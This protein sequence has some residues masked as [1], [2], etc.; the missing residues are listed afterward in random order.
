[1][2]NLYGG[3]FEGSLQAVDSSTFNVYGTGLT[4][5]G[6]RLV[7]TL[8]DGTPIDLV[9]RHRERF[10]IYEVPEPSTV[11]L[12]ALGLLS[13]TVFRRRRK[14]QPLMP[15]PMSSPACRSAGIRGGA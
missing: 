15:S 2:V 10:N 3:T 13:L 11:T 9:A 6:D 14:Q 8:A 4:F 5:V 1:V 12:A 7:G